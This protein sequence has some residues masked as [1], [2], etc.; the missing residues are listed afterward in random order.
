MSLSLE[1]PLKAIGEVD[2]GRT[3]IGDLLKA[4]GEFG[5]VVLVRGEVL[6][7]GLLELFLSGVEDNDIKSLSTAE[8]CG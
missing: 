5:E 1:E 4:N 8:R 3:V 6:L 2:I 7:T